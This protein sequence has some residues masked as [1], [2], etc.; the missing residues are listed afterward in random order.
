MGCALAT[1]DGK[2]H[3][4]LWGA[5]ASAV[6]AAATARPSSKLSTEQRSGEGTESCPPQQMG[7]RCVSGLAGGKGG[8]RAL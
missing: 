4:S 5:S 3:R 1:L 2:W 8:C 6:Q 7:V